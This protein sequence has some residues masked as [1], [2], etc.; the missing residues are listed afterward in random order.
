M[1]QRSEIIRKL[2]EA[3][4]SMSALE[5]LL[6]RDMP[7]GNAVMDI[8]EHMACLKRLIEAQEVSKDSKEFG[9]TS[10]D[11]EGTLAE[12]EFCESQFNHL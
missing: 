7:I 8:L 9:S 2:L 11:F 6:D 5:I 12:T 1:L 4:K 3:Q 10:S